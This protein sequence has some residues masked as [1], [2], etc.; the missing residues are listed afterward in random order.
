M[1]QIIVNDC[2]S[3]HKEARADIYVG[4]GIVVFMT[5]VVQKSCRNSSQSSS[6]PVIKDCKQAIPVSMRKNNFRQEQLWKRL[7]ETCGKNL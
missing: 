6:P 7:T 2:Q 3:L 1:Q 4:S 5:G